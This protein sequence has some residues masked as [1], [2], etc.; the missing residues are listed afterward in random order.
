MCSN[1]IAI[2]NR[3]A[4]TLIEVL[5]SMGILVLIMA[6]MAQVFTE[7]S[8]VWSR[9]LKDSET[10]NVGRAMM[11]FM[12]Q[13]ISATVADHMLRFQVNTEHRNIYG[14]PA[15]EIRFVP[16]SQMPRIGDHYAREAKQLIYYVSTVGGG[17]QRFRIMRS[18]RIYVR[19]SSGPI[20]AYFPVVGRDW[21]SQSRAGASEVAENIAALN[22]RV[23]YRESDGTLRYQGTAP[24]DNMP[25]ETWN[26]TYPLW[27]DIYFELLGEADANMA[28][29]LSGEQL[30]D[31]IEGSVQ[32][33]A[34]RAYLHNSH[35][36]NLPGETYPFYGD[37]E[38]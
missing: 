7:S 36:Y 11:D 37:E 1:P 25:G 38:D 31:F 5:V 4:F 23:F 18:R 19:D 2:R 22:F 34:G 13:D 28:Q 6:L 30:A 27:V 24:Y 20:I 21:T 35:G 17:E 16:L 29:N 32:R 33:F 3:G 10:G 12:R 14:L 15:D 26:G 8:A 9:G